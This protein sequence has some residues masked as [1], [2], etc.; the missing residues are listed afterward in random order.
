MEMEQLEDGYFYHIYNRGNNSDKIFFTEENYQ[1]FLKLLVKYIVPV[2]DIYAYCLLNNHFHFL[3][4]IKEKE[5]IVFQKLKFSTTK[6][7]KEI[8]ASRQFSHFFNAYSQAINKKFAR[9][10]SLFEK[11]FERKKITNENYLKQVI[12][13]INTNPLKHN[14]VERLEDYKWSSYN[15]IISKA[16]TNLK[17][18]EVIEMFYNQENFIYCHKNYDFLNTFFEY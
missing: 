15:S 18:D 5:D 14:L 3:L 1:Y 6:I 9:T 16:K 2:A 12:L 4:R 13:Y 10:G 7:P 11:R 17:R 8:S